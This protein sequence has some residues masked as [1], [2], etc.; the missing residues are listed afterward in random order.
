MLWYRVWILSYRWSRPN[1]YRMFKDI[2]DTTW[3]NA[4]FS[5]KGQEG[6][7]RVERWGFPSGNPDLFL[8]SPKAPKLLPVNPDFNSWALETA[9]TNRQAQNRGVYSTSLLPCQAHSMSS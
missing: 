1:I 2:K 5:F 6:G 3:R 8:A 4:L 9:E 7:L